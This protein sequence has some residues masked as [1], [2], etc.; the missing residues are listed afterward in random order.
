MPYSDIL[1]HGVGV[2]SEGQQI[3]A[4]PFDPAQ[5]V[6]I[7][8]SDTVSSDSIKKSIVKN[9]KD[10]ADTLE[11]SAAANFEGWGAEAKL[12][13]SSNSKITYNHNEVVFIA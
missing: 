1:V 13:L 3:R 6:E 12:D 5:Q 9:N 2:A 4:S 8:K 11:S 10:F 7:I